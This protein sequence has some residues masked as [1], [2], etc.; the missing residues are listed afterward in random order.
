MKWF[1]AV[2]ALV[3]AGLIG[4]FVLTGNKQPVSN[5][6][7]QPLEISADDH[8]EGPAEAPLTLIEYG[9][10]Q[11]PACSGFHPILEQLQQDY[12][13]K[14]RFVFRHFPLSGLHP[15]AMAAARAAEAAGRQDKFFAMH[16]I[17]YDRQK[18]WE[19]QADAASIFEGYA[20]ELGLNLDQFRSDVNAATDRVNHDITV[21]QSL[22]LSST[23]TFFLNGQKLEQNPRNLEDFKT[24]LDQ[25]LT[26][27]GQ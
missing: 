14:L 20:Q 21:G 12:E 26:Q 6:S 22:E 25:A 19:G 18:D 13:G 10:F 8:V 23:P 5:V 7:D 3:V 2:L 16:D 27:A 9:D 1:W 15:H 17:L 11:C 24:K 4:L